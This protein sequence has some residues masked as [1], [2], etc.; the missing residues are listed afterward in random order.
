[1]K[2]TKKIISLFLL[3]TMVFACFTQGALAQDIDENAEKPLAPTKRIVKPIKFDE[4]IYTSYIVEGTKGSSPP[5]SE[6]PSYP[7]RND[8]CFSS[9]IYTAHT[10]KPN[11]SGCLYVGFDA[12][13]ISD[14]HLFQPFAQSI[15]LYIYDADAGSSMLYHTYSSATDWDVGMWIGQLNPDH[16][17]YF[18]LTKGGLFTWNKCDGELY[19][20]R[21]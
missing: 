17:Y 16:E 1:M 11:A 20:G 14:N 19:I 7:E 13:M 15:N 2:N 8:F 3:L 21:D 9:S 4:D 6:T 18:R 10:Y 5:T 12:T